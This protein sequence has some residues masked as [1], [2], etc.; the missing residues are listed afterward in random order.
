MRKNSRVNSMRP[1]IRIV[2]FSARLR[3]LLRTF[4]LW[5]GIVVT[6]ARVIAFDVETTGLTASD[7]I[8]SLGAIKATIQSGPSGDIVFDFIHLVFDPGR[9]SH[10]RAEEVHG[11]SDWAL[12]HQT[13][14]ADQASAIADFFRGAQLV[15]AHNAAFDRGFLERE[16]ADAG[17]LF[18]WPPVTCTM[19]SSRDVGLPGSLARACAHFGL[20]RFAEHH[21]ALE[22]AWLCLSLWFALTGHGISLPRGPFMIAPTNYLPPPAKPTRTPNRERYAEQAALWRSVGPLLILLV[23]IAV[24]DGVVTDDEAAVLRAAA[25]AEAETNGV[26]ISPDAI[27]KVVAAVLA[28]P[29]SDDDFRA[30][31]A[32]WSRPE[33]RDRLARW[34]HALIKSD[35]RV[36][37][38]EVAVLK[39]ISDCIREISA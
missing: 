22:D 15:I 6:S 7:R 18:E 14:F 9:K 21:G 19:A 23:T 32:W 39:R 16:F 38:D 17:V 25:T 20:A 30:A 2:C 8:V 36:A 3:L 4:G 12:R 27:D 13:A 37:A 5:R 1:T 24:S 29:P 11:W 35:G 26:S 28:S 33:A 31:A 34:A 10:F